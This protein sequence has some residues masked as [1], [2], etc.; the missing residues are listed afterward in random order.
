MRN[1]GWAIV[2][3]AAAVSGC[4]CGNRSPSPDA[5]VADAGAVASAPLTPPVRMFRESDAA[6]HQGRP[7]EAIAKA[8]QLVQEQ[9]QNALAH[10]LIGRSFVAK[11][12]QSQDPAHAQGARDAF[13]AALTAD[14]AFWPALLNLAE[15]EQQ[16]GHPKE[17]AKLYAR[18]LELQPD[19]PSRAQFEA[20]IEAAR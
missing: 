18:V 11:Y 15:L 10:N 7:D 4:K 8:Q 2:M 19:H 6:Y 12:Q 5:G 1:L 20:L 13:Q 16:S 17:A 14:P 9:P 3:A